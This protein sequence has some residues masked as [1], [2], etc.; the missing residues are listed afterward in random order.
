[1]KEKNGTDTFGAAIQFDALGVE[2]SHYSFRDRISFFEAL[3]EGK[4]PDTVIR[5]SVF[6]RPIPSDPRT[7]GNLTLDDIVRSIMPLPLQNQE[8]PIFFD[9]DGTLAEWK[10]S[11]ID[12]VMTPGYFLSRRPMGSMLS[13]ARTLMLDG[14]PVYITSKVISGTTAV[15]DKNEW[16]DRHLKEI[17]KDRRF[18]IPYENRDKNKI[19]LPEGV[20]PYYVLVDD[21]THY[22]LQ[23]WS[24]TGI[25]VDNGINNTH[26]SWKG[27]MV[28]S[29]SSS[30]IIA[31]TISAIIA[32]ESRKR[33][34]S[35]FELVYRGIQKHEVSF[36]DGENAVVYGIMGVGC[37]IGNFAFCFP[38]E[39]GKDYRTLEEMYTDYPTFTHLAAVVT[40]FLMAPGAY[41]LSEDAAAYYV[42]WLT[43]NIADVTATA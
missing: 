14:H 15:Q 27:Y 25:K 2:V 26:R 34:R 5:G 42:R 33:K 8:L 31:G 43:E 18:F 7:E 24:G 22:G 3:V 12:E 23:G 10:E 19:T 13:A 30:E 36:I 29:Q 32:V 17:P 35:L 39:L 37:K 4:I 1:M 9:M 41:G 38:D 6:G 20:R 16:L 28:S 21:S 40:R 11:H